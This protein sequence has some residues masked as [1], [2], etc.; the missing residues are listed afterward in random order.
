ME[1]IIFEK[2]KSRQDRLRVK[3]K[4]KRKEKQK[5]IKGGWVKNNRNR[6]NSSE[7]SLI[8]KIDFNFVDE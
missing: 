3:E 8:K 1:D 6:L 7:K 5:K 2:D 4:F